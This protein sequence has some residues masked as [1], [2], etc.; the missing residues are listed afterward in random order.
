MG[1]VQ[2]QERAKKWVRK[3]LISI[4]KKRYLARTITKT[5]ELLE[6]KSVKK[7]SASRWGGK[8]ELEHGSHH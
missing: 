5:N 2:K 6:R 3:W 1:L 8:W 7:S 4:V